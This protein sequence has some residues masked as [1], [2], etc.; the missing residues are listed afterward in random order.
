MEFYKTWVIVFPSSSHVSAQLTS[1]KVSVLNKCWNICTIRIIQKPCNRLDSCPLI[2]IRD[3]DIS[4]RV[5]TQS[6][7]SLVCG[8]WFF[9]SL[10]YG[11]HSVT[12]SSNSILREICF[13]ESFLFGQTLLSMQLAVS[14][15]VFI[16]S[17]L[18]IRN[19]LIKS[20]VFSAWG[21]LGALFLRKVR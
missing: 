14:I 2:I 5:Q 8:F 4:C 19:F 1:L 21:F 16:S 7:I 6:V 12:R 3:V 11:K 13:C 17:I 15:P 20:T 18:A 10:L 9:F